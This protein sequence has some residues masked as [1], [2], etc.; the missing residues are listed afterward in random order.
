M[1]V[2]PP[3]ITLTAPLEGAVVGAGEVQVTGIVSDDGMVLSA[4]VNEIHGFPTSP[5]GSGAWNGRSEPPK[6]A[7]P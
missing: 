1:I 3:L 6:P 2:V 7:V 4:W 5:V